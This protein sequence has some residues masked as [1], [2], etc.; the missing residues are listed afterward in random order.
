MIL[1]PYIQAMI[2]MRCLLEYPETSMLAMNMDKD[3]ANP[4]I[5]VRE[6]QQSNM[7]KDDESFVDA[8]TWTRF[9][10][11]NVQSQVSALP[12]LPELTSLASGGY[13]YPEEVAM[14]AKKRKEGG[15]DYAGGEQHHPH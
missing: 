4:H 15:G 6:V 13:R 2:M 12:C 9:S 10:T 5:L 14:H 7:H 3:M 11:N 8:L 1:T